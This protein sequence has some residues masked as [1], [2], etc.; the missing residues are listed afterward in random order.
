MIQWKEE[1]IKA[2]KNHINDYDMGV[3]EK[4]YECQYKGC[5]TIPM[6][7]PV[8]I[9]IYNPEIKYLEI[10]TCENH[11]RFIENQWEKFKET[12]DI[13]WDWL[14]LNPVARWEITRMSEYDER[15]LAA[16]VLTMK[17]MEGI[18]KEI[19][20]SYDEINYDR[21]MLEGNMKMCTHIVSERRILKQEELKNTMYRQGKM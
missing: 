5:E 8:N 11:K 2:K 10:L 19:S 4:G 1:E 14:G 9:I 7:L 3:E 17:Y 15:V 13:I 20:Y 18:M 12:I 21:I 6:G 16:A